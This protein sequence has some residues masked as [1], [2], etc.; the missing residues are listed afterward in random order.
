MC[1]CVCTPN[2]FSPM[3]IVD[4]DQRMS[5]DKR[6]RSENSKLVQSLKSLRKNK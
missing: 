2:I 4:L 1:V 6:E 5:E 3:W